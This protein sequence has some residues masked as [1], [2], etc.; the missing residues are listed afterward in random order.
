MKLAFSHKRTLC[1][2]WNTLRHRWE[3]NIKLDPN[4]IGCEEGLKWFKLAQV[5]DRSWLSMI[6]EITFLFYYKNSNSFEDYLRCD[7]VYSVRSL[8]TFQ[9]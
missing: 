2:G 6:E 4:E 1:F 8:P 9:K 3:D 5:I 7:A